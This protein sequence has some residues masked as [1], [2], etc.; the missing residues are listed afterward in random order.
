MAMKQECVPAE[1][2]FQSKCK[3]LCSWLGHEVGSKYCSKTFRFDDG[4]NDAYGAIEK[5]NP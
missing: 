4:E 1:L 2:Q 5:Q 3:Y